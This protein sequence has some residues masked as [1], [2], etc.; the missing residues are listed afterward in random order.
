M[1]VYQHWH[2]SQSVNVFTNGDPPSPD[3]TNLTQKNTHAH[4]VSI[5]KLDDEDNNNVY[6]CSHFA[7]RKAQM[8]MLKRTRKWMGTQTTHLVPQTAF[9]SYI[10]FWMRNRDNKYAEKINRKSPKH[11]ALQQA[12]IEQSKIGWDHAIRSRIS[13]TWLEAQHLED[14]KRHIKMSVK[15]GR[16]D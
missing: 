2:K 12:I 6:Q 5:C 3:S 10:H 15:F 13:K 7:S 16:R 4:S 11:R 1:Q 9:T 8:Q 14:I